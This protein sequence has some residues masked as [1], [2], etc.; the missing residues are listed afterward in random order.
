[1]KRYL[2]LIPAA[3][4]FFSGGCAVK[5][6]GSPTVQQVGTK[7]DQ[8]TELS[9]SKTVAIAE[10][11]YIGA[12]PIV[13]QTDGKDIPVPNASVTLKQKGTLSGIA[14]SLNTI[15]PLSAQVSDTDA[16]DL[17][18]TKQPSSPELLTLDDLGLSPP[19]S[20]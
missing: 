10:H 2:S 17:Q 9:S 15:A 20:L 1:M 6:S 13:R 8:L 12:K 5:D 4:V 3:F 14:A 18:P 16:D 11:P 19:S 7:R